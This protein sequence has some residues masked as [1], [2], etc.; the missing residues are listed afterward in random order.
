MR[1]IAVLLVLLCCGCYKKEIQRLYDEQVE[2]LKK[3]QASIA[4][5]IAERNP[6]S[7][8]AIENAIL[9]NYAL[10]D[11]FQSR[12]ADLDSLTGLLGLLGGVG[13]PVG[14]IATAAYMFIKRKRALEEA[15]NLLQISDDDQRKSATIANKHVPTPK[16]FLG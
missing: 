7:P 8:A 10:D 9:S 12:G 11:E 2:P 6:N 4:G 15:G 3:R 5:E 13:G 14:G 1:F 16:E